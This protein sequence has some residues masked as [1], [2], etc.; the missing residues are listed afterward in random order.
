MNIIEEEMC[1]VPASRIKD[2]DTAVLRDQ[3]A[4]AALTGMLASFKENHQLSSITVYAEDAY[5]M[6][7]AMLKEREKK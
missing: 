7:D 3:F 4:M 6:A 5:K 1:F 2:A